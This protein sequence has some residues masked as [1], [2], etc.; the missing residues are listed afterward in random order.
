MRKALFFGVCAAA[1]TAG[2]AFAADMLVKAPPA[3]PPPPPFNWTGFYIGANIGGAWSHSTITD[4]TTGASLGFDNSGFIGG[5]QVGFNWQFNGPFV[6]GVEWD[7]DGTSISKTGP[8][9]GVVLPGGIP[10]TLQAS[11]NTDWISTLAG[12]IG[13][14]AWDRWLFYFKGGGAWVQNS[15]TLT[16]LNNGN[17]VSASN[18]NSGWVA[19]VGAEWSWSGP[20]SAKLEYDHIELDDLTRSSTLF[21]GES[22]TASRN[23]DMVKFGINYRFGW[24]GGGGY[25]GY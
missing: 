1:L 16:N 3:P 2:T 19:G 6:L 23:I 8:G 22:F 9:V 11:A 17:S 24:G 15:V 5:G 25:G 18:T 20:W 10:A 4:N 14:T 12:R 13:F 7:I 21:P